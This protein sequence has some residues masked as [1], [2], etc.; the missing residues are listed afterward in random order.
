VL[1]YRHTVFDR[2]DQPLEYAEAIYPPETWSIEEQ[3]PIE[4]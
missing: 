1:T 4:P 3:Y 2:D